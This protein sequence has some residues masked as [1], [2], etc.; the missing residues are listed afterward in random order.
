MK[1]VK[2][3]E[4]EEP[5]L[6]KLFY[7]I[8]ETAHVLNLSEKQIR[9]FLSRGILTCSELTRKKLIPVEQ[10]ENFVKAT[11]P[12]PKKISGVIIA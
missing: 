5:R 12:A 10:V 2:E 8:K 3:K 4:R 9:R 6:P 1:T 11:C 7:T